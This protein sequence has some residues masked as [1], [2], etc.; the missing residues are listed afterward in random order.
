VLDAMRG[1]EFQGRQV[2]SYTLTDGDP[3]EVVLREAGPI[4]ER[5][6][7]VQLKGAMLAHGE[8]GKNIRLRFVAAPVR[9]VLFETGTVEG[10]GWSC[11]TAR[12]TTAPGGTVRALANE[13]LRVDIDAATG[14]YTIETTDGIR[15]A[16]LGRVVDGGDGGDTYNYSPPE[17]DRLVDRPASVAITTVEDGP[18]R[19]RVR[20][21]SVYE[22][23]A[24]AHGD[25]RACTARSDD[26]VACR[27]S[28][29]L[30][31]RA[32]EPFLRVTH[33]IENNARDHRMRAHFPLPAPVAGSDAECAFTVVHRGLE[34][35]GGPH[36]YPLPTFPS[37]RFV[38]ASDGETG[39]ALLHDGLL[40]YEIVDEGREVAL[41]LLRAVGYLS[42][43]EPSLR[44]NPAGPADPLHGPQLQGAQR[45]EYA[46]MLHRGDWRAADC[47]GAADAFLVPFERTRVAPGSTNARPNS[48]YALRVDGAEVSA[49]LRN[50]GG[51]VV[52]VFRTAPD[53]GPVSIEYE[54]APARGFVVDLRGRPVAP[55]E[56]DVTLR[57]WQ[58][59]TLQLA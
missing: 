20:V 11:F 27:V 1:T 42:R 9:R 32:G 12:D 35:E 6:D 13:H 23:P 55:F 43:T 57:P 31:L 18:V 8:Q 39:L 54:G 24:Y 3:V 58:L 38:D 15:R 5:S 34:A 37:R 14:T 16:G 53:E 7:L 19:A 41:T 25:F 49:V 47:Y 44:P 59:A 33:D 17:T 45:A 50:E 2:A 26:H 40:E 46:V 52:R 10:F 36:E 48:G 4:D 56:A 21:D 29:T 51:L 28:T 30:E 22:I